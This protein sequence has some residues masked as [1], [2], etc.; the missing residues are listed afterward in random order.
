MNNLIPKKILKVLCVLRK[1]LFS[2]IFTFIKHYHSI[3]IEAVERFRQQLCSISDVVQNS[4]FRGY[5]NLE[6]R[7]QIYF[8]VRGI[9]YKK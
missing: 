9:L 3:K 5:V 4:A 8:H 1:P 6:R 2:D 7:K